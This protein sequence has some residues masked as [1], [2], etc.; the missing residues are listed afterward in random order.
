MKKIVLFAFNGD[1]MCFIHVL[2]NALDMKEKGYEVK[3]VIEGSATKLIPELKKKGN[4][5]YALYQKTK[6]FGLIDG[7]CKACSNK[8]GTLEAARAEGFK[9]LDDMSGHPGI[10][11]YIEKGFEVITF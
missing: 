3:I 5:M 9:L 8:M 10:A 4:P 1:F 7:V 6:D 11:D 2:L